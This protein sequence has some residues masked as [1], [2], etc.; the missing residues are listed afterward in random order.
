MDL[1]VESHLALCE[2]LRLQKPIELVQLDCQA[3]AFF[4]LLVCYDAR[5]ERTEFMGVEHSFHSIH[6]KVGLTGGK[7]WQTIPVTRYAD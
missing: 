4:G 5:N 7:A 1:H 6:G 2:K 3:I